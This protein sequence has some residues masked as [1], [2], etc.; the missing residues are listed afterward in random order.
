VAATRKRRSTGKRSRAANVL[1]AAA[2]A[3]PGVVPST[4][5]A[6]SAPDHASVGF[7]YDDYRDWQPGGDRM[8]VRSPSVFVLLPVSDSLAFEGSAVYDAVSGASPLFFNALS[9]ASI[10]DYRRAA[11]AKV[12]KWIGPW[13]VGVGGAYSYEQDYVSR[14]GSIDVRYSTPDNNRTYA[15]GYAGTYDTINPVNLIVVGAHRWSQEFLV[16]VTQVLNAEAIVQSNITYATG[17]GYY[18]D[19]YK[20]LDTRPDHRR[21]LAWL[22]R[23]NQAFPAHD[24]VLQLSYRLLFDSFGDH[25]NMASA[26][27]VQDLPQG[28]A[29]TP[30]VRYITQHKAKFYYDPPWPS[31]YVDGQD[32]TA[33]TRLASWGA[34]TLGLKVAKT[35]GDS[36]SAYASVDFYR[37]KPA[38]YLGGSGS[39]G[40]LDFSARWLEIGVSKTF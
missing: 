3:L 29:V 14:A 28:W 8:K 7:V 10:G 13:A 15:L 12:T 33:D 4:G 6:A 34:I 35:F 27:W 2:A 30:S 31:G 25:H 19:P 23:Y 18:S 39:R 37:Q 36:W 20:P 21:V 24:G 5:G 9:G 38:W 17:H 26:A 40:I 32:Y 11:N 22:T 16:G 1:L